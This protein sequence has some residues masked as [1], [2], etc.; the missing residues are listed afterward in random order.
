MAFC[1]LFWSLIPV[2]VRV[3]VVLFCSAYLVP[4]G[5]PLVPAGSARGGGRTFPILGKLV[6]LYGRGKFQAHGAKDTL[7]DGHLLW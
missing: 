5:F 6:P 4:V 7:Q 1:F 2:M 3:F